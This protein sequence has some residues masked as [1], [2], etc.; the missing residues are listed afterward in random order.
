MRKLLY[1]W[2]PGAWVDYLLLTRPIS[3]IFVSLH[4]AVG[5]VL[6]IGTGLLQSAGSLALAALTWGILGNGGTLAL[7]S[8]FDRDEG[9]VGLLNN[10]PQP[11]PHLAK[12]GFGMMLLGLPFSMLLGWRFVLAYGLSMVMSC[13]YSV[14]P[15][16]L[17]ARAGMDML[18]NSMGYGGLTIYAGWAAT[19]KPL[20]SPIISVVAAFA[21]IMAGGY[22][23]TQIYQMQEDAARGDRTLALAL[24]K[25]KALIYSAVCILAGFVFLFSEALINFGLIAL[26]LV[27]L[28]FLSWARFLTPWI[29]KHRWV[30]V[31]F[32]KKGF[33]NALYAF[34]LTD[35][36][37]VLAMLP[38]IR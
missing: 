3:W 26:A 10:P 24:G 25:Q 12:F 30:D 34:A 1:R 7:N 2:L 6:S 29:L 38:V 17:K 9:D 16:R 32:E 21:L 28:A 20:E 5:F 31:N 23:L 18:I 14:P 11:P 19:G 27:S 13:L 8:A 37:V 35:L 36:A 22:P 15:I 4:M 33:Y